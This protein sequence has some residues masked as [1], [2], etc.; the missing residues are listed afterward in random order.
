MT[1]STLLWL[2]PV[3]FMLHDFEEIIRIERWMQ[4]HG[5]RV[6]KKIPGF[7]KDAF[8]KMR[9]MTTP[10]MA[11][12]VAVVF[13]VFCFATYLAVEFKVFGPFIFCSVG[14]FA[15]GFFHL[16]SAIIMRNWTPGALTS[17]LLVIPYSVFLLSRLT[18]L[19]ITSWK[20]I[21]LLVPITLLA[22]LGLIRIVHWL[23][24][25]MLKKVSP[26]G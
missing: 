4:R 15:H 5:D 12:A 20:M 6:E 9:E 2:F 16:G 1:L 26:S 7:V 11:A 13:V 17:L 19:E 25:L 23:G 8:A 14:Y 21:A 10:E 3:S 18:V 22:F 24:R